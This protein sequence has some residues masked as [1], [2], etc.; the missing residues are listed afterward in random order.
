MAKGYTA[1]EASIRSGVSFNTIRY[2]EKIGIINPRRNKRGWRIFREEDI[3]KLKEIKKG[4][5]FKRR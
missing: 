1:H 5:Y 4:P 2:W 3:R